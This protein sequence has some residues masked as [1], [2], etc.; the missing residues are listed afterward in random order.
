MD[1]LTVVYFFYT[2]L[3]FYFLFLFALIYVQNRKEMFDYPLITKEHS[4]S[5]V[6]PCYNAE[7]QIGETIERLLKS[8]YEGLKKII[9]VDDCSKD[10]SYAIAKQYQKKYPKMV[11]VVKTPKNTGRAAGSKNYGAKFVKTDLIGFTDDDSRPMSDA[12]SKMIG[13][14]DDPIVG[15]V[16]SRVLVS[17][18][19][20]FMSRLQAIEYK[21]IAFTRRLLGFVGGIYVTNGPLSIYRK[22]AFDEVHG[23]DIKNLTEDIEITWHL[24]S[25]GYKIEISLPAKVYTITPDNIRDWFKQRIRWNVGGIQTINQYKKAFIGTGMLGYFIIPFF[26]FSWFIAITG[27]CVL[28]YRVS[29]YLIVRYL[30][31]KMSIEAQTAILTLNEINL[32][33]SVLFLFGIVLF[34]LGLSFNLLALSYSKEKEFKKHGIYGLFMYMFVY[35]TLYPGLLI[36]S[37]VAYFRGK[38][39]W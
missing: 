6:V 22:T 30:S 24:I 34:I 13:F 27:F 4:L 9:V 18:R 29:R 23:F 28:V 26:V 11:L 19:E 31:A 14:F 16:T 35:L 10:N 32:N 15:G 1:F 38:S 36:A 37:I 21:V 3:A 20:T 8:D 7:D 5:I 17:N 33:P 12:I 39:S 25:K 2:F